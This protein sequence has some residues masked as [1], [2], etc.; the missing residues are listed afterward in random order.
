M[1]MNIS[2]GRRRGIARCSNQ[3][4]VFII[5]AL[6]HRNNLRQALNPEN[7]EAVKDQE[8][9]EFKEQ[10]ISALASGATSVLLD[11]EFG[12][13]QVI[14]QNILPGRTGLL[15]ALEETGYTGDP[16]ARASQ[17]LPGWSVGKIRRMGA[18]GVKLLVYYHPDSDM[19]REQEDLVSS[20]AESCASFD[21]PLFLEPLSYSLDPG[22][23]SL[24]SHEKRR[25]VVETARKLTPLGADILKAE[26]PLNV[27]EEAD[28]KVWAEA[29]Q[30]LTQA[31]RVPWTLLSS[32]V[33]FETFLRQVN[34]ACET[35]A[36]GVIAGRA[37]WQEA[38][39]MDPGAMQ[40]FLSTVGIER[41]QAL[42]EIC[43]QKALP[44]TQSYPAEP[45]PEG[46]YRDYPDL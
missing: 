29:C 10:V 20:V 11:P 45:V 5:L 34:V 17:V 15:V 9:V 23:K 27:K 46:W 16:T 13:S 37:I 7:P 6:D 42:A 8:I 33:N 31:S 28:E 39:G 43:N 18:D 4:G 12:A 22:R 3:N 35:G 24:H 26:F 14:S 21:I 1:D 32:G 19:A 38:V 44:W 41:L 30:E 36:S 40:S 25:V 2:I